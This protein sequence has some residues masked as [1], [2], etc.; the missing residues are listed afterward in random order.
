MGGDLVVVEESPTQRT[1]LE[2]PMLNGA[3][4]IVASRPTAPWP[5]C[6]QIL[7]RDV[8]DSI[9]CLAKY[10]RDRFR[11]KVIVVITKQVKADACWQWILSDP[12]GPT[13]RI[14]VHQERLDELVWCRP[15]EVLE[16][17][18]EDLSGKK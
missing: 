16:E 4:G 9:Y 6:Y 10:R 12:G 8:R 11:G 13:A 17:H 3:T 7:V 18:G 5:G 14:W 2:G 1:F 15:D